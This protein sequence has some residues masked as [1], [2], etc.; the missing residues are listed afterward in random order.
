MESSKESEIS[1][2]D[3]PVSHQ[4]SALEFSPFGVRVFAV[5]LGVVVAGWSIFFFREF[6]WAAITVW[7]LV[8]GFVL[9]PFCLWRAWLREPSEL[10]IKMWRASFLWH[11]LQL[12]SLPLGLMS[13][14]G[15]PFGALESMGTPV[16]LS[17]SHLEKTTAVLML[18]TLVVACLGSWAALV[19]DRQ[20]RA[21]V[22]KGWRIENA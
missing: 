12:A 18:V 10:T 15:L 4:V 16:R 13:C 22:Q 1:P 11:L 3:E 2:Q 6:G 19:S 21:W 14:G 5:G 7:N 8:P 9:L 17:T 20:W